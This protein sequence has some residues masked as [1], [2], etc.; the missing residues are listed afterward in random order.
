MKL[1][2]SAIV[3]AWCLALVGCGPSGSPPPAP[4]AAPA[5]GAPARTTSAP[6]I[7]EHGGMPGLADALKG[8]DKGEKK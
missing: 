3:A 2:R 8:D 5:A 7:H 4:A 6:E 1:T